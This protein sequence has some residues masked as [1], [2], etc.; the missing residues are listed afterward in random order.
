MLYR[1]IR[2]SFANGKYRDSVDF[3]FSKLD[4]IFNTLK[5]ID[6]TLKNILNYKKSIN[7]KNLNN[8]I[9]FELR[10]QLQDTIQEY[11][12]KLEDDFNIP[13]AL[14]VFFEFQKFVNI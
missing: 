10:E 4:Q 8:S 5:N 3:S 2:F 12:E 9:S 1:A 11:V 14:A 7:N 6:E 13:E